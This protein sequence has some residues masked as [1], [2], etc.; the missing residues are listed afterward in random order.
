MRTTSLVSYVMLVL[1]SSPGYCFESSLFSYAKLSGASVDRVQ[2]T[3]RNGV[4]GL[5]PRSPLAPGQ[6][7]LSV[8]PSLLL[9][10]SRDRAVGSGRVPAPL[11]D[12]SNLKQQLALTLFA[13]VTC[14]VDSAA[15]QPPTSGSFE[16]WPAAYLACLPTAASFAGLACKWSDDELTWLSSPDFA[17]RAK[18]CRT[19]RAQF[20][21]ALEVGDE[22]STKLV[23]VG[24]TPVKHVL[25]RGC[26]S[27]ALIE[28]CADVADSRALGGKFGSGGWTRRLVS[29]QLASVAV[30]MVSSAA[31]AIHSG[32]IMSDQPIA[33]TVDIPPTMLVG[34]AALLVL[35]LFIAAAL[36]RVGSRE[37]VAFVPVLDLVNHSSAFKAA[38]LS[39]DLFQA[40][41]LK[42]LNPCKFHLP[43]LWLAHEVVIIDTGVYFNSSIHPSKVV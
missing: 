34:A 2:V 18:K 31:V 42:Y 29:L 36:L 23:D 3:T 25:P 41:L 22:R 1:F 9:R 21:A 17:A 20:C 16:R 35:P 37:E 6:S 8:P 15:V 26:P 38:R 43:M 33:S 10:P 5:A 39:Y 32:I 4:R 40:R 30:A 27:E 24:N 14:P 28:W 11:Y 19:A 12:R 13:E 7:L